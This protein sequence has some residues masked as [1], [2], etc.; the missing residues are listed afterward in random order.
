MNKGTYR[1]ALRGDVEEALYAFFDRPNAAL[2]SFLEEWPGKRELVVPD[3]KGPGTW[4][5]RA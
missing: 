5:R 1:E 4:W 2:R 3:P